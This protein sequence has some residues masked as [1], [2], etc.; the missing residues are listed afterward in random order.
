V[1]W[2]QLNDDNIVDLKEEFL[3][4]TLKGIA[5]TCYGSMFNDDKEF[6][7]MSSIYQKVYMNTPACCKRI[8]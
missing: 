3:N 2:S 7:K 4:M 8:V 5:R 1:T 6:R